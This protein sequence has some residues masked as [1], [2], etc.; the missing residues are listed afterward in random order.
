MKRFDLYPAL[1]NWVWLCLACLIGFYVEYKIWVVPFGLIWGLIILGSEWYRVSR[2]VKHL[3]PDVTL[4]QIK[5][6]YSGDDA[7][8]SIPWRD[9][10][11]GINTE[12]GTNQQPEGV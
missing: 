8:R 5:Q 1:I 4:D 2:I 6:Y 9:Q 7:R 3:E 10:A 12:S 11:R